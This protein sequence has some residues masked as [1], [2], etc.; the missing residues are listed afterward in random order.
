MLN[1][2]FGLVILA[3]VTQGDVETWVHDYANWYADG[4]YGYD[5]LVSHSL[6]VARCETG[7][8][9]ERVLNNV[10]L[11]RLGEVGVGQFH[12]RGIW[13]STPQAEAGYSRW[14]PEA[15]TAALV[16]AISRGYGP[17]HWYVCWRR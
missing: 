11:G 4:R 17:Q 14:D 13:W 9:D 2:L 6:R 15:N 1:A 8:W 10:R 16:W 3:W 5:A 12:S 7:G